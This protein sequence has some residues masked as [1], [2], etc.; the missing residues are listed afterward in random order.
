LAKATG[1]PF[2]PSGP[3]VAHGGLK[4]TLHRTDPL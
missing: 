1:L 4:V 3:Q 2:L